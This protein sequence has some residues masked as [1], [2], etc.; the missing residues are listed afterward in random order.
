MA[1]ALAL[2]EQGIGLTRPNPPV[3]AVLVRDGHIVGRGWHQKAGGPH[4]EVFALREAGER[5]RGATAYVTLEPCSTHGRTPA[6]TDALLAAGVARVVYAVS[7]PNPRHA[8][9]ARRLLEADGVSVTE[10]VGRDQAA[11]LL[12]PFHCLTTTGRPLVTLKLATSLDGRIADGRGRS[13]WITG[14]EA[15]VWV[16]DLR[17]RADGI[18]VG[19][20]TVRADNPSLLPRPAR[21]RKPFRIVLDGATPLPLSRAVFSDAH[22]RQ[23]ILVSHHDAPQRLRTLDARGVEVL[24]VKPGRAG[25]PLRKVLARLGKRGL[26]HVVCE[27]GGG[28]AGSLIR[29]GLAD[30]L[31][32]LTAPVLLG[33]R[34]RPSVAA[35]WALDRAPRWTPTDV[36]R[37]GPDTLTLL[38]PAT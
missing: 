19:A 26:L 23:T 21:G 4:A 22:A 10:G 34:G 37:L 24:L 17:R 1:E 9:R 15:R 11:T 38:K 30:R 6:C 31:A 32:W 8:G 16:Q 13:K 3:G 28:V 20:G 12:E 18:L 29:A 35:T 14:P 27:G 25:Y 7:D 33:D 36:Q 2:A 5:A